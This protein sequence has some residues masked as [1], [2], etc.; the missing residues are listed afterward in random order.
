[1]CFEELFE[2]TS[3]LDSKISSSPF[4]VSFSFFSNPFEWT[5][6]F[7][8]SSFSI[9][10][11]YR[12]EPSTRGTRRTKVRSFHPR[13][14]ATLQKSR[15]NPVFDPFFC[16]LPNFS[17]PCLFLLPSTSSQIFMSLDYLGSQLMVHGNKKV[18]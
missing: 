12:I 9:P 6:T 14:D 7:F 11:P 8:Y 10:P 5:R 16:P 4:F 2:C 15:G 3:L 18:H 1:M 13:D 17:K